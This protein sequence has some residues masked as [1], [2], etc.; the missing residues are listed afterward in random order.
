MKQ[1]DP[2]VLRNYIAARRQIILVMLKAETKRFI[3][4]LQGNII[5]NLRKEMARY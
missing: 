5:E 4:D 1:I 3:S 2:T